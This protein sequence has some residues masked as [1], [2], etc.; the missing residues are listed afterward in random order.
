MMDIVHI[1]QVDVCY[2]DL[3]SQIE[4]DESIRDIPTSVIIV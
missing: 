4:Y 2:K 3:T 1:P